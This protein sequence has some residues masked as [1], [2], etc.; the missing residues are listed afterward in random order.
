MIAYNTKNTVAFVS[1]RNKWKVIVASRKKARRAI[2]LRTKGCHLQDS[3][4]KH[5]KPYDLAWI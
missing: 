3:H 1:F 5:Y 4:S 2:Y